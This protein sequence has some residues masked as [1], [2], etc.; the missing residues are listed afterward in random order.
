[1]ENLTVSW[2]AT[3]SSAIESAGGIALSLLWPMQTSPALEAR[4]RI[5]E[6]VCG[7]RDPANGHAKDL[8]ELG[9]SYSPLSPS[10]K[11]QNV[12]SHS[13]GMRARV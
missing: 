13:M 7:R 12:R 2:L 6:G 8:G 5:R 3:E 4:L 9:A 1:M 11:A 10:G